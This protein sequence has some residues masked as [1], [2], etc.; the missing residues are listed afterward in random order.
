MEILSPDSLIFAV[1]GE[2]QNEHLG[3]PF[4]LEQTPQGS[5]HT[6]KVQGMSRQ[7][8]LSYGLVLSS[9]AMTT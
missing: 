4:S 9:P 2:V 3:K 7:W 1:S 8:T 6:I 5:G